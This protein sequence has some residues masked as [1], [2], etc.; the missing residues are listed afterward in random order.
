MKK[1]T[2]E[3]RR[4]EI[5]ETTCEV[6][7]ERGFAAT[8]ISDV[9]NRLQ[10]SNSLIHYHF[11]SK[12]SLLAAAFEY[13]ALKD[14]A[15]ME[16]DIEAAP[17]AA[18]RLSRLI[19]NYVPEGSDDLEWMLWIDGWGEALR[20]PMMKR[21]SQELDEQSIALVEKVLHDGVDTGEFICADPTASAQRIT[22]LI[23]GLAIQYAAHHGVISREDLITS[24]NW[25]ASAEVGVAIEPVSVPTPTAGIVR[26]PL[27]SRSLD[28]RTRD[29][30]SALNTRYCDALN[31]R[32]EEAF[33]AL[34]TPDARW[35][36]DEP[37]RNTTA[38]EGL[39]AIVE[40][41]N[42]VWNSGRDLVV[43][44]PLVVIEPGTTAGHATARGIVTQVLVDTNQHPTV[45]TGRFS[46]VCVRRGGVWLIQNRST[47]YL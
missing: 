18:E 20:N 31:A 46:A 28:D 15:E 1:Q 26:P 17:T 5:L 43:T 22:G 8:R 12:E 44:T 27:T 13:Y 29:E 9:A 38:A 23:D 39:E 25:L 4:T 34:W 37:G 40:M 10:V 16:A 24:V 42:A 30:L 14:I 45:H 7:I 35:N 19:E 2:V 11:D 6:V 41:V 33:I 3:E 32:D 21:I 36:I 47:S